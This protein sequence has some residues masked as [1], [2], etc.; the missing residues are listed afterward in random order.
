MNALVAVR[1]VEPEADQRGT[2]VVARFQCGR[3]ITAVV[4]EHVSAVLD[5]EALTKAEQAPREV[6]VKRSR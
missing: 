3:R 1:G 4:V 2:N 6:P 5:V